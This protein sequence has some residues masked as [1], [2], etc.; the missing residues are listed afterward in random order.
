M[1]PSSSENT[2]E[3]LQTV[4]SKIPIPIYVM[5]L[6]IFVALYLFTSK[7]LGTYKRY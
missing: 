3:K 1:Q 6:F 7:G 5:F 2:F 4:L